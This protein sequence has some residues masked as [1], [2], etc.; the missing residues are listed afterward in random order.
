[1]VSK[2]PTF[3]KT[4]RFMIV[5][6]KKNQLDAQFIS[7]IFRQTPLHV[8]GVSLAH[9]QEVHTVW[10]QQL[11]LIVVSIRC[12]SW[13]WAR[14]TP[15]T[16]TDVWRNIL[17]INCASSWFFFKWIYRDARSIK[18]K[19]FIIVLTIASPQG[20]KSPG[21]QVAVLTKF[22]TV[23]SHNICWSPVWNLLH[24][25]PLASRTLRCLIE[26]WRICA[27]LIRPMLND[28]CSSYFCSIRLRHR[29]PHIHL[30]LPRNV[31]VSSS[32]IKFRMHSPSFIPFV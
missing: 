27:T 16:R 20:C 21:W 29:S 26:F 32:R 7:S 14:D 17:K 31:L 8:S 24:V 4:Q 6:L 15:K 12:T 18:H 22:C 11:V 2:Y 28:T 1:M 19:K 23:A 10:I 9:H 5:H 13:W 30:R 3:Y 25:T